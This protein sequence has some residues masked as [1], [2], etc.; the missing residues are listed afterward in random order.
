MYLGAKKRYI[1]TLPFLSFNSVDL[2]CQCRA[3]HWIV[4]EMLRPR[5]QNFGR[6]SE[7]TESM[8]TGYCLSV[9]ALTDKNFLIR[10]SYN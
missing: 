6:I 3:E 4:A 2:V 1:N 10:M 7:I 8:T 9:Y 5:R